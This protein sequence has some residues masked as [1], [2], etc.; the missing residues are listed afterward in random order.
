[1]EE[2]GVAYDKSMDH[3]KSHSKL[4][5]TLDI[6]EWALYGALFELVFLCLLRF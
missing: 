4:R 1:M 5:Q 2:A 3:K 6:P